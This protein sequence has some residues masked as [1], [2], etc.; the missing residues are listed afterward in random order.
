MQTSHF[1]DANAATFTLERKRRQVVLYNPELT[2]NRIIEQKSGDPLSIIYSIDSQ[3]FLKEL[4]EDN[5][6]SLFK[7]TLA[8]RQTRLG[9]SMWDALFNDS[10]QSA[11]PLTSCVFLAQNNY[12]PIPQDRV[13]Y[14]SNF[15]NFNMPITRSHLNHVTTGDRIGIAIYDKAQ[16]KVY[17]L[18]YIVED[19]GVAKNTSLDNQLIVT[20]PAANIKLEHALLL[21]HEGNLIIHAM[22]EDNQFDETVAKPFVE[23]LIDTVDEIGE[24]F[25]WKPHFLPFIPREYRRTEIEEWITQQEDHALTVSYD[26]FEQVCKKA[27][28]RLREPRR[29]GPRLRPGARERDEQPR[30][31]K[32]TALKPPV[33]EVA[34]LTDHY[35]IRFKLGNAGD[36]TTYR[37]ECADLGKRIHVETF[38]SN[39]DLEHVMIDESSR[40]MPLSPGKFGTD[41]AYLRYFSLSF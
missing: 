6:S 15:L 40:V 22:E 12:S 24:G 32:K 9:A 29:N 7:I 31:E 17:V 19:F 34:T 36:D 23:W 33:I 20:V 30:Q 21:D 4:R 1:S 27:Y 11:T 2:F 3:A 8:C 10:Q 39:K 37:V 18:L 13:M 5:L 25:P 41:K 28:R 35:L 38:L 16:D 14:T 26:E